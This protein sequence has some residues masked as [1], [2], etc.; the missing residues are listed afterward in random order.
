[1]LG[2]DSDKLYGPGAYL[3]SGQNAVRIAKI[4][5][6][7]KRRTPAETADGKPRVSGQKSAC[8]ASVLM[9]Y[10]NSLSRR[11]RTIDE[12]SMTDSQPHDDG[13]AMDSVKHKGRQPVFTKPA[14]RSLTP[15]VESNRPSSLTFRPLTY[16][17]LKRRFWHMAPGLLPLLLQVIPHRDPISPTLR[18]IIIGLC[19]VIAGRI[20]LGFSQIQRRGEGA[21][22]AAVSGYT[23]SVLL[24]ALLFPQHLELGLSVLS[25]L[26]FGDG[27]ATLI[28]LTL[29]GPRL[30]WN[31]GKSWSGLIAFVIVGSLM[32]SW[33]YWGEANGAEAADPAVSFGFAIVLTLPAVLLAG[34]A[35]SVRSRINDNVRVG[36]VAAVALVLLHALRP[37]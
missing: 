10:V 13:I 27:S 23:L 22:I 33:I 32:T 34:L 36:I 4:E 20:L 25:I 19:V 30:P 3:Q 31:S 6:V 2:L 18:W 28:G 15:P 35:E 9:W 29:R 1:M 7:V 5:H 17:E 26:A 37:R 11:P 12:E 16:R 8:Q 14:P 24:T 21:G